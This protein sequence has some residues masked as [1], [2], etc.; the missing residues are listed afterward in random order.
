M[1]L[2]KPSEK[3][4]ETTG[5]AG[6]S[7]ETGDPGKNN[8]W[9]TLAQALGLP[10]TGP[11]VL[12]PD[13]QEVLLDEVRYGYDQGPFREWFER[14]SFGPSVDP[15]DVY[16][17]WRFNHQVEVDGK[18]GFSAAGRNSF[19]CLYAKLKHEGLWSEVRSVRWIGE[20]GEMTFFSKKGS[21]SLQEQLL[22]RGYGDW[23]SASKESPWG[24][25]SRL[26]GAQL[27]FR[28]FRS[29]TDPDNVHIDLHN[30][31][32][33]SPDVVT[34]PLEELSGAIEHFIEDLHNRHESHV[35]RRLRDALEAQEIWLPPIVP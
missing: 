30:P 24:V 21:G 18:S 11:V 10:H 19:L 28:G 12:I 35:W 9:R 20:T 17:E 22:A 2:E 7:G 31:G 33:P 26:R 6:E 8:A 1:T 29:E 32:D 25:R 13:L 14:Y 15:R 4:G 3:Q 34:G 5:P 23:W 27:H 16:P